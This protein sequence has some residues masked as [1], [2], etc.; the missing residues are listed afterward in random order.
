MTDWLTLD[1][2]ATYLKRGRS[3]LYRMAQ[4]GE[5]PASKIGRTWR[6][7]RRAIDEWLRQQSPKLPAG[8][9]KRKRTI[10]RKDAR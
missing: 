6:F 9:S 5:L 1:E 2:L 4:R 10:S 3:T 8:K 7:E